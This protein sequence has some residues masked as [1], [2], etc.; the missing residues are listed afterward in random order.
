MPGGIQPKMAAKIS[1]KVLGTPSAER[2]SMRSRYGMR[3]HSTNSDLRNI[4]AD[5]QGVGDFVRGPVSG[6]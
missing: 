2:S 4:K 6:P 1:D 3:P 5:D